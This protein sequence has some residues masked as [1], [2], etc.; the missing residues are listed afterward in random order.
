MYVEVKRANA[1]VLEAPNWRK[2]FNA[3][4]KIPL[5]SL[6]LVYLCGIGNLTS[7]PSSLSFKQDFGMSSYALKGR[8]RG[9]YGFHQEYRTRWFVKHL[10]H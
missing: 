3:D 2:Y 1:I 10:A 8:R 9:D 6:A 5:A 7:I 4:G